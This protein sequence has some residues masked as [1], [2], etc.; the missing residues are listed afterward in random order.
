MTD[1]QDRLPKAGHDHADAAIASIW[2]LLLAFIVVIEVGSL[3]ISH[4]MLTAV[5]G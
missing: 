3:L 5:F 4:S 2:F 1:N